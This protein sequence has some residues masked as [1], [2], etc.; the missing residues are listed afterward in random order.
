[1][2]VIIVLLIVLVVLALGISYGLFRFGF[3]IPKKGRINPHDFNMGGSQYDGLEEIIMEKIVEMDNTAWE[4]VEITS[5]D[6]LKLKGY[7]LV[8][9][10]NKPFVLFMHGYHGCWQWDGYGTYRITQ[11]MGYNLLFV[12][13]RAHGKSDGTVTCFAKKEQ[14]DCIKWIDYLRERFGYN[15]KLF[16]S[17]VSMGCSIVLMAAAKAEAGKINGVIADCGFA[18]APAMIKKACKDMKL[19]VK[20]FAPLAYFG[21]KIYGNLTV[22]GETVEDCVKKIDV[23]VIFIHGTKDSIVP[24]ENLDILYNACGSE[25]K[26]RLVVEDSDHAVCAAFNYEAYSQGIRGFLERIVG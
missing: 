4:N 2:K 19:P 17:G 9:D 11:D 18:S 5:Y 15:Q 20:I 14:Y 6:G 25:D 16:I 1:M 26:T 24:F 13:E 7:L 22:T 23:P 3:Y 8:R 21:A 12:D 10:L